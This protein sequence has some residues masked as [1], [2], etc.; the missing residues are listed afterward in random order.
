M[1]K[2]RYFFWKNKKI[3]CKIAGF[4]FLILLIIVCS[5]FTYFNYIIPASQRTDTVAIVDTLGVE[6]NSEVYI[7]DGMEAYQTFVGEKYGISTIKIRVNTDGKKENGNLI[8][9]L[10]DQTNYKIINK[11]DKKISKINSDGI[12]KLKLKKQ[13]KDASAKTYCLRIEGEGLDKNKVSIYESKEDAFASGQLFVDDNPANG[14]L[15]FAVIPSNVNNHFILKYFKCIILFLTIVMIII[16]FMTFVKKEYAIEHVFLVFTLTFGM[17]YLLVMPAFSAPD[18]IAHFATA[19]RRSNQMM[20]VDG[21]TD[22]DYALCRQADVIK[23]ELNYTTSLETYRYIRTTLFTKNDNKD[24]TVFTGAKVLQ[25]TPVVAHL[26]QATGISIAR[27][28]NLSDVALCFLGQFC[29]FIFYTILAFFAIKITPVGKQ[30]FFAISSFPMVMSIVPSFSYD[31]VIYGL[32]FILIAIIL[33]LIYGVEKVTLKDCIICIIFSLLLA[34][35]KMVYSFISVL[36]LLIPNKKFK[37]K[38]VALLFKLITVFASVAYA[39][40]FNSSAVADSSS[41]VKMIEWAGAQGFTL[42]DLLSDIPG[43]VNMYLMTIH[44]YM[45]YYVNTMVGGE[46]G[47][48]NVIMPMDIIILSLIVLIVSLRDVNVKRITVLQKIVYWGDFLFIAALICT[49]LLLGWTHI[50]S[51]VI[52]GI[53]GRYFIPILPLLVLPFVSRTKKQN[54]DTKKWVIIGSCLI[55][56]FVILRVF[57]INVLR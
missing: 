50:Y 1:I 2:L 54:Y 34:P 28:L 23:R 24:N 17:A 52:L 11:W 35:C 45:G 37:S 40:I 19:Y 26:A 30:I 49:S 16:W 3:S 56:F 13:I 21:D 36:V 29:V 41:G 55:N 39:F 8:I 18:E 6:H 10:E 38:K 57:E 48:L 46:L 20:S 15:L 25:N 53:Q 32:S 9:S 22:K 12:I 42:S 44:E 31:P 43:T 7:N 27:A 4:L 5:C 47:W 14:D 33:R 51:N